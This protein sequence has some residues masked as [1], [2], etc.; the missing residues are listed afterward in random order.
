MKS[1]PCRIIPPQIELFGCSK[2]PF[3]PG[4]PYLGHF[5]R[6]VSKNKSRFLMVI[7]LDL[8]R[9]L[10]VVFSSHGFHLVSIGCHLELELYENA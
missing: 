10:L 8:F 6:Q 9:S 5:G 3:S 4:V 1:F 7:Y 2:G